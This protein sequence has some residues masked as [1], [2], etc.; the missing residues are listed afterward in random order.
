MHMSKFSANDRDNILSSLIAVEN[1]GMAADCH[2]LPGD[3]EKWTKVDGS[4]DTFSVQNQNQNRSDNYPQRQ[5]MSRNPSYTSLDSGVP[6]SHNNNGQNNDRT[7][8]PP[9]S[10]AQD[11]KDLTLGAPSESAELTINK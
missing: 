5:V 1:A 6:Q 7:H 2:G 4:C 10:S 9:E 11:V 3:L 8:P